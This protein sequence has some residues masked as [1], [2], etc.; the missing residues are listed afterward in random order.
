MNVAIIGFG[1]TGKL[2]FKILKKF[3]NVEVSSIYDP[4]EKEYLVKNNLYKS[5]KSILKDVSITAV[6][7]S[8]PNYLNKKF[9]I[10]C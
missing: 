8:V 3:S 10:E 5:Y 7:I 4:N 2:K 9:T 6:F 1:K